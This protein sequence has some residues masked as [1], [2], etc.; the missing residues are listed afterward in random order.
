[1]LASVCVMSRYRLFFS[2]CCW[3]LLPL[4]ILSVLPIVIVSESEE[5]DVFLLIAWLAVFLALLLAFIFC[6]SNILASFVLKC[7]S[8]LGVFIDFPCTCVVHVDVLVLLLSRI[9]FER[10]LLPLIS[11]GRFSDFLFR[12]FFFRMGM[13]LPGPKS[14][15]R[16]KDPSGPGVPGLFGITVADEALVCTESELEDSLRVD[17]FICIP[18]SPFCRPRSSDVGF[19]FLPLPW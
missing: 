15:C 2:L 18:A 17:C 10:I 11:L 5:Q 8:L 19:L 7:R 13:A 6:I 12:A 1:M 3:L 4:T 9:S 16:D 14:L